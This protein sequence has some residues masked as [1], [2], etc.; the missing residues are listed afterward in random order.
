MLLSDLK[1]K[2]L[3][4]ENILKQVSEYDIYKY[5]LN[6]VPLNTVIS[7]PFRKDKNP[8]FGIFY[9]KYNELAF[10]DYKLGAGNCFNFVMMMNNVN[11]FEAL[12]IINQIFNL[13]LYDNKPYSL[14]N[15]KKAV[16]TNYIPEKK[17]S[18]IIRIK[19]KSVTQSDVDYFSPLNITKIHNLYPIERFWI[20]QY[21]FKAANLAYAWRYGTNIYK[22]YQ[23]LTPDSKWWTNISNNITWYGH[24]LLPETGDLLF[25]A[26][27]NKDAAVLH[28]LGYN[29]IAPH[30]ESQKFSQEQ[31]DEYS[32]RFDKIIIFYDNDDTGILKAE[33][34]CDTYNLTYLVLEETNT[35]D[36]FEF[37]KK[38]S[39]EDLNDFIIESL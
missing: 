22:I 33:N 32:K 38:Y 14:G 4:K 31:Y 25:V 28:Q 15:I 30:T 3:N 39:L 21:S 17:D 5:Y 11:Y 26:S 27:S 1:N 34:F 7:S 23:P 8:S 2:Q 18:C 35:K 16:I 6:E 36:P 19:L 20:N 29:A 12:S 9:S 10:N 37:V 24:D 13:E